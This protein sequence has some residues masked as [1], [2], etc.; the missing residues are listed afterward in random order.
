M[1]FPGPLTR[2]R[3]SIAPALTGPPLLAFLPALSLGAFW[4]GGER[5]LVMTSLGLPLCLAMLGA[6][7]RG[8]TRPGDPDDP[9]SRGGFPDAVGRI[10]SQL[11]QG[12]LKSVCL[13]LEIEELSEAMDRHGAEAGDLLVQRAAERVAAV[14]RRDDILSQVA[15][16]RFGVCLAPVPHLD[17]E[18]CIQLSGRLQVAIEEPIDIDGVAVYLSCTIGF[19]T[20]DRNPGDSARDWIDAAA[21]ALDDARQQGPSSIR[22]FGK[23]QDRRQAGRR[24]LFDDAAAALESGQIQ[25]WFQPQISTDTG[26]VT[27]FEALARWDHPHHGLIAPSEF[28]P[29]LEELGLMERLGQVILFHALTALKSWDDAGLHVPF[30]AV[31]FTGVELRSPT[32]AERVRWEL[33]RF[34][35]TPDRLA[36]EILETVVADNPDDAL[37][38]TVRALGAMGCRIDLDDF[39]T[40]QASIAALRRFD[41][42][43]IKIDRS[44]IAKA[45]QDP[46]QQRMIGAILTMA[47]RLGLETLGEG[48]ETPGEHAILAQLGC[49]HVQGFV[50]A[51]PMPFAETTDWIAGHEA[52]LAQPPRI[53]RTG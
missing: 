52:R 11:G 37:A 17:L 6:F 18:L 50:I 14:L 4:L 39:G 21:R 49:S 2:L 51:R 27:G 32:L 38:R 5:A 24:D 47:E 31:N 10:R 19:C 28:L 8:Q 7:N 20:S 33:D 1:P 34:D 16:S 23:Q 43:R 26:R 13:L 40:G 12:Q 9:L 30:I 53:G 29:V 3:A 25:P 45:D 41:I 36:V 42:G 46:E 48:V 35:L 15:G 44:F 22:S